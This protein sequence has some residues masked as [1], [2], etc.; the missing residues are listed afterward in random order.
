MKGW[1]RKMAIFVFI[2]SEEDHNM[3]WTYVLLNVMKKGKMMDHETKWTTPGTC[4]RVATYSCTG[5]CYRA[6]LTVL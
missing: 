2:L 3:R 4:H 5:I 1:Y 6:C